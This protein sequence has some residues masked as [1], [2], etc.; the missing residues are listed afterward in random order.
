MANIRLKTKYNTEVKPALQTKF[1]YNST[2]QIPKITKIIIN[3]G[4]GRAATNKKLLDDAVN[5]LTLITGQKPLIT[6]SKKSIAAFK[7]REGQ[8]IGA[9]VSLRGARMYDFL[10]KL[11]TIVIPRIRDFRGLNRKSF[12]GHGNYTFGIKEQIIFPE[13]D[14]DKVNKLRGMDITIVTDAKNNNEAR[15]L[16]LLMGFPFKKI[17]KE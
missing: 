1:N 9:K 5:E 2:M 7:L 4:V 8:P 6:T 15:E 16:L 14:Y 11:I 17:V 13:I 10:D 3:M 12:D